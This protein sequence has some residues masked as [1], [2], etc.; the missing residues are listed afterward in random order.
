MSEYRFPYKDAD[1]IFNHLVDFDRFCEEAGLE[2]VN[3]ELASAMI[4]MLGQVSAETQDHLELEKQ[5]H[6]SN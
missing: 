3:Q 2:E 5:F 6:N 1:F 4:A